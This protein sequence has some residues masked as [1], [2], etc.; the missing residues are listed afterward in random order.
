MTV[1]R[2]SRYAF[3]LAGVAM[4]SSCHIYKKFEMPDDKP[5]LAEY[6]EAR[7]AAMDSASFGNMRW[8]DMF[9]DPMLA[10]LIGR[11]LVSNVNLQNAKLN[12]DMAHS[13]LKGARLSYLPSLTLAASGNKAYYDITGMRDM[14]WTYQVPLSASWEIDIF[15][16]TS[17][18]SER[19]LRAGR[20]LADYCGSGQLLLYNRHDREAASDYA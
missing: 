15:G 2:I 16:K 4:L 18:A 10:D 6:V 17:P 12:V 5:V 8:Q 13:Q 20:A 9:T 19:G 11:A 3:I 7:D 14:P 1:N